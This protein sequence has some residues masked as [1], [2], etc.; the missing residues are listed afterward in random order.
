MQN[1]LPENLWQQSIEFVLFWAWTEA[2]K[3]INKIKNALCFKYFSRTK[4]QVI[5]IVNII[6]FLDH[7]SN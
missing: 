3:Q 7:T 4:H 6:Q 2:D 1:L 5:R